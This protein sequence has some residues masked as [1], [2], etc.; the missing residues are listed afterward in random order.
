MHSQCRGTRIRP[1]PCWVSLGLSRTEPLLSDTVI[2]EVRDVEMPVLQK[3]SWKRLSWSMSAT[4]K[5]NPLME[6]SWGSVADGAFVESAI[7]MK[8]GTRAGW[9]CK[10]LRAPW[11]GGD[12]SVPGLTGVTR[13]GAGGAL[14]PWFRSEGTAF[15][16]R[17]VGQRAAGPRNPRGD[18]MSQWKREG[19]GP[20]RGRRWHRKPGGEAAAGVWTGP[21]GG[22]AL[23]GP[24]AGLQLQALPA[25]APLRCPGPSA[26]IEMEMPRAW[27]TETPFPA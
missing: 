24:M 11:N 21:A 27:R 16:R 4:L 17:Q 25:A 13:K 12:P 6:G 18:K 5:K 9:R 1:K 23:P 22:A 19:A 10:G 14:R 2:R 7:D 15:Q 8:R 26:A 20:A 3:H